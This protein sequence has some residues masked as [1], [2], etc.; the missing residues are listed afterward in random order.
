MHATNPVRHRA[1]HRLAALIALIV[2]S[3]AVVPTAVAASPEDL[4]GASAPVTV[5]VPMHLDCSSVPATAQATAASRGFRACGGAGI[6]KA[7]G[8]NTSNCGSL[9]LTV[10]NAGNGFMQ[11][12]GQITSRLGP[13][14]SA[15][16]GGTW[17]NL[18]NGRQ[19]VVT[20]ST[21]G[22]SSVWSDIFP[23]NSGAG[24]VFGMITAAAF[25]L[26]WGAWCTSSIPVNS[27][28]NVT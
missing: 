21:F 20:R 25:Q 28:T 11:W 10:A 26:W 5:S 14:M 2:L 19:A 17:S 8:T 6:A 22:F 23:A 7:T 18:A 3:L 27:F 9:S 13:F 12:R 24:P 15:S 1:L 16:Y 4:A